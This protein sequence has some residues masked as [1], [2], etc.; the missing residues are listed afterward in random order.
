MGEVFHHY[1]VQRNLSLTDVAD[2]IV[3]KQAVSS[4][5]RDQS[6]MNSAALVAMLAR[7]HV[8]VQ[9]FCHDYAYDGSYQQLLLELTKAQRNHDAARLQTLLD[10]IPTQYAQL[11]QLTRRQLHTIG[12]VMLANLR[13]TQIPTELHDEVLRFLLKNSDWTLYDVQLFTFTVD[14]FSKADLIFMTKYVQKHLDR[15]NQYPQIVVNATIRLAFEIVHRL[16]N[17][18]AYSIIPQY[19]AFIKVHCDSHDALA[20]LIIQ[21][22]Q[23]LNA[24]LMGQAPDLSNCHQIITLFR[25]IGMTEL[26]MDLA[27]D[28]QQRCRI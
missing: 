20:H 7:M 15:L 1:R 5:E 27:T 24:F 4:F 13:H 19:L 18:Q 3:T 9:E 6:T 11:D 12:Q 8:S 2:H 26:A 28:L 17:L 21:Y 14:L 16:F 25:T 22:D 10:E 23:A